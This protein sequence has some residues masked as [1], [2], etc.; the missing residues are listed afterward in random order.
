MPYKVRYQPKRLPKGRPWKI[1]NLDTG[2][3]VGSSKTKKDAK[4]SVRMRLRGEH[5]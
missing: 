5:K 4:A 3:Q 1:I 2:K